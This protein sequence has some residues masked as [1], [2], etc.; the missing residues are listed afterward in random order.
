MVNVRAHFDSWATVFNAM[1]LQAVPFL[2][3]GVVLASIVAVLVPVKVWRKSFGHHVA[4]SIPL[5]AA[6]GALV[7]GCECTTVPIAGRLTQRGVPFPAALSFALASPALNPIVMLATAVAFA[8]QPE[9]V[10]ARFVASFLAVLVVGSYLAAT[11]VAPTPRAYHDHDHEGGGV[12]RRLISAAQHDLLHTIGLVVLGAGIAACLRA[13][14]PATVFTRFA[15]RPVLAVAVM[16]LLAIV[17]ALCSESD[18]FVAASFVVFPRTA[19]LAFMV[20]GPLVDIR[21]L[22]MYRSVFG[23][24]AAAAIGGFALLGAIA[25]STVVGAILL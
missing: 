15:D 20:V 3:L 13:F 7:P 21:L 5:A 19:L 14:V 1:V 11:G 10:V 16:A 17:L 9:M 2:V 23:G 12:I 6:C 4:I 18:A 24:R 8:G 25:A 22:L